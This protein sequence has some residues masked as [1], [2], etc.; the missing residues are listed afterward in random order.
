LRLHPPAQISRLGRIAS[1]LGWRKISQAASGPVTGRISADPNPL[2]TDMNSPAT[3]RWETN[4]KA[5]EIYLSRDGAP[6]KLMS[7]SP[8]RT[9]DTKRIRA[10][11]HYVFR[12][13]NATE[14]RELLHELTVTRKCSGSIRVTV[15]SDPLSFDGKA[16]LEWEITSPAIAE[17]CVSGAGSAEK[18]LCLG[19]SGSFEVDW[20]KP[21]I[22]YSFRLYIHSPNYPS[23]RQL[24]DETTVRW[25][26]NERANELA[27]FIAGALSRCLQHEDYPKWLRLWERRGIHVTPVHFYAPIP[28][29]QSLK[30]NLWERSPRLAGVAM[31]P[32]MQLHLLREVFPVFKAEYQQIPIDPTLT[33]DGFYLKN[34]RFEGIDAMLAYCII[35]HFQPRQ[36]I[37]VGGGYST[38]LLAQAAR[39]NGSTSLLTV[40]PYPEDFLI[41][42]VRGLSSVIQKKIEDLDLSYFTRLEAGDCLFID[43]SHVVRIGGDVNFLFLEVLPRLQPGVV[44]HVHDI[45]LPFEY[46]RDWV[47]EQRRFWTEQYLLQAFLAFNSDFEV[48]ISSGY[49]SANHLEE[50]K[51]IFPL[52]GPWRGGSFW[53]RRK[54]SAPHSR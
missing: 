26:G 11:T 6:E 27:E 53:M 45:F 15:I 19:A 5:A 41:E 44:I 34:G 48:L 50:L 31:N 4:A 51:A 13:Y 2:P 9:F 17:V 38:L 42:S 30:E 32:A 14:S 18:I 29:S 39:E 3:V 22:D 36:I 25:G 40:E 47:I 20:L 1:R 24:L 43:S 16:L 49:L 8:K 33:G 46:P 21:E 12:L 35:R 37:E 54:C 7:R 23:A 10:G 52:C 28:D